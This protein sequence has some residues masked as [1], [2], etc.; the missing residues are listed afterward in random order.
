MDLSLYSVMTILAHKMAAVHWGGQD[1][2]G[3]TDRLP[4]DG[5]DVI[6]GFYFYILIVI[7]ANVNG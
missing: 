1:E 5:Y 3:N 6:V 4:A 7:T 2:E